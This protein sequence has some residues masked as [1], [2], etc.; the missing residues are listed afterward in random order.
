MK[1][2]TKLTVAIASVLSVATLAGTGYAGWVISQEA[3]KDKTGNVIVYNVGK[4]Y[5]KVKKNS[6]LRLVL[7]NIITKAEIKKKSQLLYKKSQKLK[8][9][10]SCQQK[11]KNKKYIVYNVEKNLTGIKNFFVQTNVVKNTKKKKQ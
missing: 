7:Q 4:N 5:I 2:K 1:T 6:V 10:K 9:K 3:T 8:K 11:K